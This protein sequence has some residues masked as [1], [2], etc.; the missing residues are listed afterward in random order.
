[1]DVLTF[2][3]FCS[4]QPAYV[5][6]TA[7]CDAKPAPV[8]PIVS[9]PCKLPR[10][11]DAGNSFS[12]CSY[13]KHRGWVS[14]LPFYKGSAICNQLFRSPIAL[15]FSIDYALFRF[16][17][18]LSDYPMRIVV[19]SERSESKDLTAFFSALYALFHFAHGIS[20][21]SATLTKTAG[22]CKTI[23][24]LVHSEYSLGWPTRPQPT[25]FG[26]TSRII[27]S[28]PNEPRLP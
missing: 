8:T 10:H 26:P 22:V 14:R 3:V 19:L 6:H 12:F 13:A 9:C 2:F 1:M 11:R 20:P 7:A 24:I 15:L 25:Q 28:A 21:F 23:P 27:E 4:H 5:R 17:Y 16:P 18:V